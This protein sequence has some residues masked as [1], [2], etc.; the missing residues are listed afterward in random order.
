MVL[1]TSLAKGFGTGGGVTVLHDK[2]MHRK[3]LTCGS[4]YTFSGPVQPPMLGA[5]IASAKIHL[6][7]EIY[8]LQNKLPQKIELTQRII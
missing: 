2:E 8:S 6:S 3:I 1:T 7:D 5:S 4:S